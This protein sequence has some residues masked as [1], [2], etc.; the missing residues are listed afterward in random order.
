MLIDCVTSGTIIV[1]KPEIGCKV[2]K[3]IRKSYT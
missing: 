1:E 2:I 3:R